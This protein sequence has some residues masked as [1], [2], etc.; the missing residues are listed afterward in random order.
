M[1]PHIDGEILNDELVIIHSSGSIGEPEVFEP[2]TEVHFLGV[3]SN[4]GGWSE[5]LWEQ[6]SLDVVTKVLWPRA[7]WAGA[8]VVW[9]AANRCGEWTE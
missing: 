6:C 5:A 2:Y 3:S 7:I 4:V 9:S 1:L 8:L